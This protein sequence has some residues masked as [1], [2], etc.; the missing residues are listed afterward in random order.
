[1]TLS[2]SETY[3]M[4][5]APLRFTSKRAP[6]LSATHTTIK[7]ALSMIELVALSACGKD[8]LA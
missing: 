8:L 2:S 4:L 6:G 5:D 7:K 3:S 1:M